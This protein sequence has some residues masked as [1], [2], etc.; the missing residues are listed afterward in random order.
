VVS[1]AAE[2]E[3][4]KARR[5]RPNVLTQAADRLYSGA[6]LKTLSTDLQNAGL[7]NA[8]AGGTP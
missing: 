7:K 6:S 8:P 4:P 1:P 2:H 5:M 3:F